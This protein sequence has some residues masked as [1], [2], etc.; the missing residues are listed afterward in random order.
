MCKTII[1]SN[2]LPIK[3]T[4]E[5]GNLILKDSEGG[6]ATGLGS[7]YKQNKNIWI[8]WPGLDIKT[9]EEKAKI[10]SKLKDENLFPV[11]LDEDEIQNYYEGF[12][13]EVLWPI[14]H[15]MSTYAQF[16]QKYWDYYKAVNEKF[17]DAILANIQPGDTVWIQDYQLLLLPKLIR[18]SIQ[19]VSIGFFQHIPFPS[20]EIFRLIPWREEILKGMLGADLLGFHT[21]DDV[22][23]F[24]SSCTRLLQVQGVANKLIKK[25]REIMVDA[26]PMGIDAGKYKT[27]TKCPGVE[28]I[29][30]EYLKTFNGLKVILSIDRLDYSK[31]IIQRIEALEMILDRHPEY[32][33]KITLYMI[34]VPSRDSIPQYK[35]LRDE[36]DKLVG[37]INARF[38]TTSW[39]PIQYFYRSF[40]IEYLSAIYSRA[41]ICLVTPMRDGMN[42]VS[43]EYVASRR[44]SSGVLIL[45]EMAGASKELAEAIIINPNNIGEIYRAIL[46]ALE[47]PEEEQRQR[48][49]ALTN[50][51]EKFDIYHWVKIFMDQLDKI[52]LTQKQ[53]E[54]RVI[55]DNA[56]QKII[57]KKENAKSS[58]FLLDYDGTLVEFK[59]EI[60]K[61]SPDQDLYDLLIKLTEGNNDVV[62]ISGRK[63][64]TLDKWFGSLSIDLIA[65]HGVWRKDKGEKEWTKSTPG[66]SSQWKEVVRPMLESYSDRTPGSFIEEK[67]FSLAWHYRKVDSDLGK[68]RASELENN[69]SYLTRE[70]GLQILAGNKVLEVKS[71]DV[72]KGK[73]VLS[74][75]S[76]K[77]YDFILAIGDDNTDEDIFTS[78]PHSA[79][80]VKVGS[81]VTSA[82]YYLKNVEEARSLLRNII[83]NKKEEGI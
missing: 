53:N 7:I 29:Y 74:H 72:N 45:S 78:L 69:L 21:Y 51:V 26:F 41:D 79:I 59:T 23:H 48:M 42:L 14:F 67:S 52:K 30:Q 18:D 11:F 17:R 58:L 25:G 68:L 1:I 76:D 80:T 71:A 81:K 28:E 50:T 24:L 65:E 64:E 63:K 5:D 37:N 39:H 49:T 61:A 54:T 12:S 70:S 31:G 57:A 82:K 56:L 2:R 83:D 3:I 10:T 6:L 47:M 62:I 55:N 43:K 20:F 75:I 66:L 16:E 8:G 60:D 15:Y 19:D 22:R 9:E 40:P 73:A 33:N 32:I 27:L 36:I 34:V 38:R 46:Q 77:N 13:N 4:E 44:R 35:E